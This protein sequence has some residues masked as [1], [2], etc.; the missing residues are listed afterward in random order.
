MRRVHRW[1]SIVAAVFLLNQSITGMLLA[2]ENVSDQFRHGVVHGQ[3]A[4]G[5]TDADVA[6]WMHE[7]YAQARQAVPDAPIIGLSVMKS[8]GEPFAPV[9]VGGEQAGAIAFLLPRH[10]YVFGAAGSATPGNA[11]IDGH[12]LL[13][14]IHRGDV[15][16]SYSGRFITIAAGL[17]LLWLVVSGIYMYLDMLRKR[18]QLG[19]TAFF[20]K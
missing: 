19:R 15:I 18:R 8:D 11:R 1:V 10:R 16:G 14:R 9:F 3:D 12:S 13:K 4:V 20:W 6:H 5:F 17:C 7:A 2:W